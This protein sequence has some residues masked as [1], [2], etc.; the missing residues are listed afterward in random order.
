MAWCGLAGCM[1]GVE[2]VSM[3]WRGGWMV[4]GRWWG[5]G[6]GFYLAIEMLITVRGLW[7][8]DLVRVAGS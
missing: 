4:F 3:I 6:I 8:G 2:S 1:G 5:W 7:M